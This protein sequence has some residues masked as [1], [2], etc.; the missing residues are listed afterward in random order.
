MSESSSRSRTRSSGSGTT[1]TTRSSPY[2]RD[3]E[4][5]LVD[6]GIYPNNRASN[7]LNWAEINGYLTRPGLSLSPSQLSD[8]AFDSFREDNELAQRES[9]VMAN[10]IPTITGRGDRRHFSTG[11]TPFNN[12]EKFADGE[13]TDRFYGA[14]PQD[15]DRRVRNDLGKY[16]VPSTDT[17]LSVA[18]NYFLEATP[19]G[20]RVD[21]AR[22]QACHGGVVGARAMHSLQNYQAAAPV[23]DKQA[24]TITSTYQDGQLK[25]YTTNPTPPR[26]RRGKPEHHMTQLRSF[27]M[28]D[29]PDSFRQGAAAYRNGRDWARDQRESFIADANDVARRPSTEL[30]TA[31]D[32]S[33]AFPAVAEAQ[34]IFP[35]G[36]LY[37]RALP[38]V[39]SHQHASEKEARRTPEYARFS[40]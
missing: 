15:I 29:T 5:K 36:K 31:E 17:R 35:S 1:G 24:Y 7:P 8:G 34:L 13:L 27:A 11:D 9:D 40:P 39:R 30:R 21:V 6:N 2:S 14:E 22:R 19:E 25:M 3:F 18:P 32:Y 37:R 4:Q 12:L 28:T 26:D 23:F 33:T 20:G 38:Q 16:I 10:V